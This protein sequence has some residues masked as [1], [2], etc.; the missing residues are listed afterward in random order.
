MRVRSALESPWR[1]SLLT[2]SRTSN[3][4]NLSFFRDHRMAGSSFSILSFQSTFS[5][6]TSSLRSFSSNTSTAIL[7]RVDPVWLVRR[8]PEPEE[9][10]EEEPTEDD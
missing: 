4:P 1:F 2:G 8:K 10:E 5:D 9:E 6:W 7:A 3:I